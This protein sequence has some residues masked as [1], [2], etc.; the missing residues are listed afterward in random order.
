VVAIT[1][2][3]GLVVAAAQ[4][5]SQQRDLPFDGF[6]VIAAAGHPFG[7]ADARLALIKARE[8]GARA[9]AI[10]PFLWQSRPASA[11]IVRGDDMTDDELRDGIDDARALGFAVVV[12]PHVWVPKSWAGTIAMT[13]AQAWNDWFGN[14]QRELLRIA[15]IADEEKAAALAIGTELTKTT[16]QPQ[17]NGLIGAVR[18]SYHGRLLYVAHN[19]DEAEAVP[20]WDRLDEVGVTL[21]PPLGADADRDGRRAQMAAIADRLDRLGARTGKSILVGEIGLRSA[22]GAAAR[23]WES[24]EER[25]SIADASLQADVLA[26]WLDVLDRPSIQGVMIWRWF[27]DPNAGGL[28]DTDFTVQGKPAERVLM[29]VWTQRCHQR[30]S[31]LLMR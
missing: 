1:A 28:T 23:P 22:A 4:P 5:A 26:D 12:K 18:R 14:Y 2:L 15:R 6:N 25:S 19:V 17:W 27:T 16:Q 24:A 9:I 31:G 7:S 11:G 21:Y 10:V 3:S 30:E 8:L 13:S 29:C 20:F